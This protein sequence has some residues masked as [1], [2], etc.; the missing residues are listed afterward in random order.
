M[1]GNQWGNNA[2][3]EEIY[4]VD[5]NQK[6]CFGIHC[7]KIKDKKISTN[8]LDLIIDSKYDGF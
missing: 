1:N 5:D 7:I 3:I 4:C 2:K 6:T 8:A